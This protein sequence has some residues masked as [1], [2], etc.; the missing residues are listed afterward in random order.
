MF[1][2]EVGS[3]MYLVVNNGG[4]YAIE[5][6][7]VWGAKDTETDW[8]KRGYLV[9][10]DPGEQYESKPDGAMIFRHGEDLS[11][12]A[13]AFDEYSIARSVCDHLNR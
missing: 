5:T 12:F 4:E 1:R 13:A 6:K 8:G 9:L 2:Q 7:V 11:R 10:V 3:E